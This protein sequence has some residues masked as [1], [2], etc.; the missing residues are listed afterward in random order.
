MIQEN[1]WST[2]QK[3]YSLNQI[4]LWIEPNNIGHQQQI[5]EPADP[6]EV[7]GSIRA[8][9]L[10][11]FSNRTKFEPEE[12]T[13]TLVPFARIDTGNPS[14][15]LKSNFQTW[16]STFPKSIT[17]SVQSTADFQVWCS[18]DSLSG[19]CWRCCY[20]GMLPLDLKIPRLLY[21]EYSRVP[22]LTPEVSQ[23][24]VNPSRNSISQ[25][26]NGNLFRV[27]NCS[28]NLNLVIDGYISI[29]ILMGHATLGFSTNQN[30]FD[31][32]VPK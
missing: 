32:K 22:S 4:L 31:L 19:Q 26:L 14:S 1:F 8:S 28:G 17:I 16:L 11:R 12:H 21:A 7:T 23:P 30:F 13:A 18:Y 3:F 25:T 29:F 6:S 2:Q 15:R 5:P 9:D 20:S 24:S 10:P 27:V